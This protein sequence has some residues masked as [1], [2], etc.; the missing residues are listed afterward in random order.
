MTSIRLIF[1][2]KCEAKDPEEA[3]S[4]RDELCT[5]YHCGAAGE[6]R[7]LVG[8]DYE[9][10]IEHGNQFCPAGNSIRTPRT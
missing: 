1:P 5:A 4:R 10:K 9:V 2:C 6:G 7:N 3:S 8:V